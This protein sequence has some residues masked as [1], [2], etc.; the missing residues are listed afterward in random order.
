[1]STHSCAPISLG[2]GATSTSALTKRTWSI[3]RST[4]SESH[5]ELYMNRPTGL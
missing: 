5:L 4:H 3:S 1:M 2:F